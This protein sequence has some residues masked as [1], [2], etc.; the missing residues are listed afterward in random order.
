M[1]GQFHQ[2]QQLIRDDHGNVIGIAVSGPITDWGT[3]ELSA[4]FSAEIHQDGAVIA[5]GDSATEVPNWSSV[6]MLAIPVSG[7]VTPGPAGGR[8]TA[9]IKS[10]AEETPFTWPP[11]GDP[12]LDVE[13]V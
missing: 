13:L 11:A 2:K 10:G 6:W 5:K 8:A 4:R 7:V 12:P 3:G 9:H 1:N